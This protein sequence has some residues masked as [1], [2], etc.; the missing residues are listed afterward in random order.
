[1]ALEK[2]ELEENPATIA[3]YFDN[4]A[5]EKKSAALTMRL[6]ERELALIK[7]A[8]Q[9][10]GYEHYQKWLRREIAKAIKTTLKIESPEDEF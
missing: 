7:K 3:E 4:L 6:S 2:R 8:A 10:D 5:N 9:A 1:M